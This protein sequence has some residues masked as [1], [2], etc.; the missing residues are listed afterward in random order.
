MITVKFW[1]LFVC[2]AF[3]WRGYWITYQSI[4]ADY[5]YTDLDPMERMFCWFIAFIGVTV[6]AAFIAVAHNIIIV[7]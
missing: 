6:G 1:Q 7:W 5:P 4:K 3:A 2:F